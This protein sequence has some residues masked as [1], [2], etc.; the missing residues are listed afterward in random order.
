MGWAL[1]DD[2]GQR[3]A[4]CPASS[5][6]RGAPAPVRAALI[7]A[8][9][10]QPIPLLAGFGVGAVALFGSNAMVHGRINLQSRDIVLFLIAMTVVI[11][12]TLL[13]T[14]RRRARR[15]AFARLMTLGH[16]LCPSCAYAMRPTPVQSDGCRVCPEC[17]SAWRLAP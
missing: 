5:L 14:Q 3:V 9:K 16:G 7:E 4:I 17:G 2:R 12:A 10:S 11:P 15:E 1:L 13:H 8:Q 6:D